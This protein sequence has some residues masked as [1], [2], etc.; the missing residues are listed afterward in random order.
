[1]GSIT[2]P[3]RLT[4]PLVCMHILIADDHSECREMLQKALGAVLP[5]CRFTLAKDGSHAWWEL[6]APHDHVDLLIVDVNMPLVNGIT[7][8]QRMREHAEYRRTPI[9]MC[10]GVADLHTVEQAAS[11]HVS[12]YIVKP[13]AVSTLVQRVLDILGAVNPVMAEALAT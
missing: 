8:A 6:T 13:Y 3:K 2:F 7:L 5:D 4:Q 10:T 11:L 1:M 12:G 9:M